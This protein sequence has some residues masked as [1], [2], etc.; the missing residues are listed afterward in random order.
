MGGRSPRLA[1]P[2]QRFGTLRPG[3]ELIEDTDRRRQLA[4]RGFAIPSCQQ[5]LRA[6]TQRFALDETA[7]MRPR[8]LERAVENRFRASCL[9]K[10]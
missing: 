1:S 4:P 3:A 5:T 6:N 7:A 10:R 8:Q 9:A 2:L